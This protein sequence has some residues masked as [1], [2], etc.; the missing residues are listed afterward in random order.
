METRIEFGVYYFQ[1]KTFVPYP[2]AVAY[3]KVD[4]LRKYGLAVEVLCRRVTYGALT[5]PKVK[6][7]NGVRSQ[8]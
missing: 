1:S 6:L 5:P 7:L 2:E 4:H 3:K 8:Q